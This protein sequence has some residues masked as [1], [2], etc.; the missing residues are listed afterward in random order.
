MSRYSGRRMSYEYWNVISIQ[1]GQQSVCQRLKY[2][3]L[4]HVFQL[5]LP[6]LS[7]EPHP[8]SYHTQVIGTTIS[9]ALLLISEGNYWHRDRVRITYHV[10]LDKRSKTLRR[11]LGVGRSELGISLEG[12]T[13][14]LEIWSEPKIAFSVDRKREIAKRH[15]CVYT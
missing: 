7:T 13:R 12:I 5:N 9:P 6:P 2:P 3:L 4:R 14:L 15:M 10:I 11:L 8:S 1:Q